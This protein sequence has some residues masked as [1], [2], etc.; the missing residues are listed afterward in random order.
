M[1][2]K[3]TAELDEADMSVNKIWRRGRLLLMAAV[4][5]DM[6]TSCVIPPA[7][8]GMRMLRAVRDTECFVLVTTVCSR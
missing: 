7:C 4:S 2:H 1:E 3:R 6:R 8:P 5:A